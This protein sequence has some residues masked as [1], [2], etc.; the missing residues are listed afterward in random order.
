MGVEGDLDAQP[1]ANKL[2]RLAVL[3][4]VCDSRTLSPVGFHGNWSTRKLPLIWQRRQSSRFG[5]ASRDRKLG[6]AASRRRLRWRPRFTDSERWAAAARVLM[7]LDE[8]PETGRLRLS[9][10][11]KPRGSINNEWVFG[12]QKYSC[13]SRNQNPIGFAVKST[14]ILKN[15]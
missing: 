4:S 7:P 15:S 5:V 2:E 1:S 11:R 13:G 3:L 12:S 9:I 8:C 10:S 6:G 14:C